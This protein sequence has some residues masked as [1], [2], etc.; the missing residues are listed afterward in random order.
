MSFGRLPQAIAALLQLE[1]NCPGLRK[2][3]DQ[4]KKGDS[5]LWISLCHFICAS[6]YN[7]GSPIQRLEVLLVTVLVL[8][9][10]AVLCLSS[11]ICDSVLV[12]FL[13]K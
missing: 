9:R 10:A 6:A 3:T 1:V 13:C 7:Y 8:H 12:S 11:L 5:V 2:F 4:T